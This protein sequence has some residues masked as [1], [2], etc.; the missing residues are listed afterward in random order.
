LNTQ[1]TRIVALA[2]A[3]ALTGCIPGQK[4]SARGPGTIVDNGQ[5]LTVQPITAELVAGKRQPVVLPAELTAY[6]PE[7]YVVSPGDTLIITVWDH[8]ELTTPAGSQQQAITNGR[9][10]QSD[11]TLFYPYAGKVKV[12]GMTVESVRSTLEKRLARYLKDPQVDVNVVG[13]GGSVSLQGA[14]TNTAPQDATTVPQTLSKVIGR[15]GVDVANADLSGLTLT[16]DGRNYKIDL[17]AINRDGVAQDIYLK[18]GDRV[19]L[20]YNDRKEVYVVGEARDPKAIPFKTSDMS[21]TQALGRAGGLNPE[22]SRGNAVY[23]IRGMDDQGNPASVF[24]LDATSPAAFAVASRF[25]LRAGDVVW[26]GP[27]G[28]TRWNRYITQLLPFSGLIRNAA[29]AGS[30]F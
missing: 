16:R 1:L 30:D 28:I 15:A 4:M 20:P 21:L 24:N 10:V 17:D 27:A 19:Y 2:M 14:F 6:Q 23:V 8:P 5:E 7:A 12:G 25:S 22:T 3:L 9:Q 11:G 29:A 13:F 26:I 18:P